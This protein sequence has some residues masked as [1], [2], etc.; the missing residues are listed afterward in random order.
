MYIDSNI[1]IK[2][3]YFMLYFLVYNRCEDDSCVCVCVHVCVCTSART[4]QCLFCLS[5]VCL[6]VCEN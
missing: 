6:S 3:I 2:Q 1:F 5:A 4:Y